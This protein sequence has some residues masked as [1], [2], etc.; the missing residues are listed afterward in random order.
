MLL[1]LSIRNGPS[2]R[3]PGP[4]ETLAPTLSATAADKGGAP[5]VW[6]WT[7][8]PLERVGHPPLIW[9]GRHLPTPEKKME[10]FML[11]TRARSRVRESEDRGAMRGL[12]LSHVNL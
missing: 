6:R 9:R 4:V 12:L 8:I 7:T 11:S 3:R 10:I 1:N 2:G 5:T